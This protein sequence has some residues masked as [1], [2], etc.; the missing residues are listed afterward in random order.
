MR[1]GARLHPANLPP[2]I[3]RNLVLFPV[4]AALFFRTT[5]WLAFS[6]AAARLEVRIERLNTLKAE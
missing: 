1:L 6:R 2:A 3:D 5:A 4:L